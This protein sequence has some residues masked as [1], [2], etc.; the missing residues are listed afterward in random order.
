M[1]CN[2]LKGNAVQQN[3]TQQNAM[4]CHVCM[5]QRSATPPGQDL[6]VL[7]SAPSCRM[8]QEGAG[9]HRVSKDSKQTSPKNNRE[10][11]P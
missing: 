1:Y 7:R 10:A 5:S 9:L 6:A 4:Q 2:A 11:T 8:S 3:A